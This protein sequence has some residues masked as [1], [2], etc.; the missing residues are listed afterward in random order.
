VAGIQRAHVPAVGLRGAEGSRG[1]ESARTVADHPQH[2]GAAVE[3]AVAAAEARVGDEAAPVPADERGAD[4]PRRLMRREAEEHL[5][6]ELIRQG[7]RRPRHGACLV[8]LRS[9]WRRRAA[10]QG[11]L[12]LFLFLFFKQREGFF[13]AA[14]GLGEERWTLPDGP[15]LPM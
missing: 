12:F 14:A 7:R 9:R 10:V 11:F 8:G 5:L 3:L 1:N 15:H 6:H 2:W 4:E 13:S